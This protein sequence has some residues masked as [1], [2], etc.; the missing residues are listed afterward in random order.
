MTRSNRPRAFSDFWHVSACHRALEAAERSSQTE[1][2]L[3]TSNSVKL[4]HVLWWKQLPG[5]DNST[6]LLGTKLKRIQQLHNFYVETLSTK[7]QSRTTDPVDNGPQLLFW[8]SKCSAAALKASNRSRQ[9]GQARLTCNVLRRLLCY[10]Q[11]GPVPFIGDSNHMFCY[12]LC[13]TIRNSTERVGYQDS[14]DKD[15]RI[16]LF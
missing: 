16:F 9:A 13:S 2:P 5:Q 15:S 11:I 4:C 8:S 12:S 7:F 10:L 1:N 14:P 6:K 3:T